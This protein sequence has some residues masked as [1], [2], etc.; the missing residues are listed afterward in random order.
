MKYVTDVTT[1]SIIY[2]PLI[3]C[4]IRL[5]ELVYKVLFDN[6]IQ[7]INRNVIILKARKCLK[8]LSMLAMGKNWALAMG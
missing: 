8:L 2:T 6:R 7:V 4:R 3:S 5:I 1:L